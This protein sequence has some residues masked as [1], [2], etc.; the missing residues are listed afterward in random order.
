[1]DISFLN[2]Y[3][4]SVVLNTSGPV[5]T[6]AGPGAGKTRT[7][8]T[9]IEYLV[10]EVGIKPRNMLICTFTNKAAE[11]MRERLSEESSL[12]EDAEKL[13]MGTI[14]SMAYKILKSGRQSLQAGYKMPKIMAKQGKAL[15]HIYGLAKRL[16]FANKDAKNYLEQISHFKLTGVTVDNYKNFFPYEPSRE[17][18]RISNRTEALHIAYCEYQDFLKKNRLMDFNDILVDCDAMLGNPKYAKFRDYLNDKFEYVAL[19]E[20]QDTNAVSFQILEKICEKRKTVDL[21]GDIKQSIYSF[22]SARPDNVYR[23]MNKFDSKKIP[24]NQNYRSTKKI[25]QYAN[26]LIL[27]DQQFVGQ[28]I[29]TSN[30]EGEE[31]EVILANDME[32]EAN[33]IANIIHDLNRRGTSFKD[34]A[35]LCRIHSQSTLLE[36][37]LSHMD[38]PFIKVGGKSFYDLPEVSDIIKYLKIFHNPE[39]VRSASVLSLANRPN[40]YITTKATNA[41]KDES[42]FGE[43]VLQVLSNSHA[44]SL[45]ANEQDNLYN[46][47]SSME[48]GILDSN[49]SPVELIKYVLEKVGYAEW[50]DKNLYGK[51]S[52]NDVHLNFE[53]LK[54]MASPFSTLGKFLD[55]VKAESEAVKEQDENS[56]AVK[57][58]SIH[59][60][61]GQ[62]FK[63]VIVLGFTT[64]MFPFYKAVQEGNS[65][66]ERRVTYVAITRPEKKLYISTIDG[67][68]GKMKVQPSLYLHDM[69]LKYNRLVINN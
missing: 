65:T 50:A 63:V 67:T 5:A 6:L 38:V 19:D 44:L 24:L 37:V 55:Y 56:D 4:K 54:S 64:R 51:D 25:V 10:K 30:E 8:V 20:A 39:K 16:N 17:K 23:F 49:K 69:G 53:M 18:D 48:Q 52:D 68:M 31:A 22:M 7:L 11:V 47:Y 27:K 62:E 41:V 15:S 32:E 35:V 21:F 1:M 59:A 45:S 57:I 43:P 60:S 9:K 2:D 66:E 14:H 3:Q 42:A 61:K 26:N 12:G 29:F 28:E 34:I 33:N 46:F 40:R 36:S 13:N 58:M